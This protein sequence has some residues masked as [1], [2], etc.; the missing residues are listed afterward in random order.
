[1]WLIGNPG[2]RIQFGTESITSKVHVEIDGSNARELATGILTGVLDRLKPFTTFNSWLDVSHGKVLLLLITVFA[3]AMISG[4]ILAV[5]MYGK[6]NGVVD[7]GL[8]IPPLLLGLLFFV[9]RRLKPYTTFETRLN[10]RRAGRW[11][12]LVFGVLGSLVAGVIL[13]MIRPF[14]TSLKK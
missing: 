13:E 6:G 12:W 9:A 8:L 5:K 4:V 2:I 11:N 3:G 7:L 1:M 14:W 10:Q